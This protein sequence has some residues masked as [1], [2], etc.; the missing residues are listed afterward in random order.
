MNIKQVDVSVW[1]SQ[2]SKGDYQ[3]TSAYQERTIDP[4]NFYSLVLRSGGPINSSNYSNPQ[5]DDLIDKART[6]T[7]QTS[8]Q[9]LYKQIRQ[10]VREDSPLVFVHY[11]TINYLMPTNV[12]GST[13]TPTLEL[14]MRNV[15]FQK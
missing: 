10:I 9:A 14:N 8:R 12:V 7:D 13:V 2:F 3:I 6:E 1:F 15:G 4:D 5:V 11:E